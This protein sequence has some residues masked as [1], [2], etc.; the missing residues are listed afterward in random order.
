MGKAKGLPQRL[1]DHYKGSFPD[2]K[3]HSVESNEATTYNCIA[4]AAGDETQWWE[5][6]LIP[7]PGFYWP[8]GAH[9]DDD[10]GSIEAL[11]RCYAAIGYEE[12]ADGR[13][14]PG[15]TKVA[16][17]AKKSDDYK[18]AA[19]L[20]ET[21]T[22]CSKLGDGYDIHHKTAECV[23]GP[24]YG[25]VMC[26]MKRRIDV[27]KVEEANAEESSQGTVTKKQ[28]SAHSASPRR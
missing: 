20:D 22:W 6:L 13:F 5:D 4:F 28:A 10:V 26:Y 3:D 17:Y 11:K 21:G 16:L 18:H 24:L 12:C 14:E 25:K 1:P 8:P 27:A 15:Y 19:V 7:L 9:Q 2:L 23:S